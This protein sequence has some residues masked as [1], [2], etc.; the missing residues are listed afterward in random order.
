MSKFDVKKT[1]AATAIAASTL[2]GVAAGATLFAP[3][4]AGAQDG[5]DDS[6][7]TEPTRPDPSARISEALQPLLDD[8]TLTADQVDAVVEALEAARPERGQRGH[9]GFG[10]GADIA[11]VLGVESSELR[12][13]LQS[14]QTIAEVAEANGVAVQ[15]VVD[16]IVAATEERV[17]GALESGRIDQEQA[18]E[19]L[20]GSAE[21]A[22]AIV[23]GEIELGR[24][25]HGRGPGPGPA[26]EDAPAA[27]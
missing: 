23:N 7:P 12:D 11:E 27:A 20:A 26:P 15:D 6:T 5:T 19:I 22:D 8:G 3:G 9:R 10:G 18:D 17:N 21:R 25:G 14:G 4:F 2:G 13:A 24:R 1:V 16:A